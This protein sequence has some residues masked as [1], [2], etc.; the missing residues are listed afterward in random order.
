MQNRSEKTKVKIM[1]AVIELLEETGTENVNISQIAERADIAVGLVN[2]HFKSKEELFA[3]SIKYYIEKSISEESAEIIKTDCTP[4]EQ[5]KASLLG[6]ADFLERH[7]FISKLFVKYSVDSGYG[8]DIT[9][10][11]LTHYL[12]LVKQIKSWKSELE[13]VIAINMVA[14]FIHMAFVKSDFFLLSFGLDFYIKEQRDVMINQAIAI[15]FEKKA[16][17]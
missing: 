4:I 5:L 8:D 3:N 12:P 11:G 15:A 16:T 7:G 6:Y 1:S 2:Y 10:M 14:N 13:A 17:D 9:Q